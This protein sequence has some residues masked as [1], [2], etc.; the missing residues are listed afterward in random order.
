MVV[1]M[2]VMMSAIDTTAVVLALPVMMKD[3]HSDIL[4]LI[5]VIMAYL[6][7]ITVLGMQVG[8]LGDMY[9]RMR[10]YNIGFAIFTVGSL[11]CG[12]SQNGMEIIAFRV[13]QGI[14]GA[15]LYSNSGAI[16]AD[17]FSDKVRGKAFGYTAVGWSVGAI[18]GI[19]VGG[20]FVTFLNWRY[21]FLINLPIGIIATLVGYYVLREQRP[22]KFL[23]DKKVNVVDMAV[24][25]FGLFLVL[26]G[27]TATTGSGFS[28]SVILELTIG[29]ALIIVFGILER[30]VSSPSIDLSLFGRRV[31][32]ASISAAFLQALAS[33]AVLFI[34]IMYLQGVRGLSPLD[35]SLLLIPGYVLGGIIGPF[36]GRL[37]DKFGARVLASIGLA[38]QIFGI[39]VYSTLSINTSYLLIIVG[40]IFNGVGTSI[41]FPANNSAVMASTPKRS[42]G[43]ASGVLRT[44]SN[45]GMVSS[46][47]VALFVA[48]MSIPRQM[49][50]AIFLGFGQISGQQLSKAFVDGI[51]S[52]LIVSI[53]L[54]A[55]AL[56]FSIVRGKEGDGKGKQDLMEP[57]GSNTA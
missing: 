7:I 47:A 39:L 4:S 28:S 51:H 48:S 49:A 13:L 3:L 25:A 57:G 26:H 44:L 45:T 40:A 20:T 33:Y 31:L 11:F 55:V 14:G 16:I 32:A 35:A 30:Q 27:L 10:M 38:F 19:L 18:L 22:Q 43:V 29:I 6:L 42:Y 41:F 2:G 52:A 8:K 12:L 23:S 46:F 36:A 54:L 24:L 17:T 5:W 56:I 50:F 15:L 53:L 21:I 37:S 9:G 34:I 1:M